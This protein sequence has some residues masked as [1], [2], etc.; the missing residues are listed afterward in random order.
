MGAS[1]SL[2]NLLQSEDPAIQNG[3]LNFGLSLLQSKG[4]FGNAI[5]RAGQAGQLGARDFRQ[6]QALLSR[7]S[8]NDELLKGNLEQQRRMLEMQNLPK[9]FMRPP[10][11]PGVDATGGMETAQ[12]NPANASGPG[13]F[14]MGG[15]VNALAGMDPLQALQLR[16][17]LQTQAP[18]PI[19]LGEGDQLLDP[20]TYKPVA[21]NPKAVKPADLP[22]A[23]QEY[24][25]A[26]SQGYKGTFNDWVKEKAKAGASS[27]SVSYGG[28]TAG[29]DPVTGQPVFFQA[30][31]KGGAPSIVQGVAPPKSD[32]PL[33]E[34][35]AKAATFKS[36]MEAAERELAGNPIDPTKLSSQI[37]VAVAS[38]GA[39]ILSSPAAQRA[40]QAQ[41]QWAESFLRFK[42]GAASTEAEVRRNV[43]TFFPQQ[44]D[45][46]AVID[47]KARMRQQAV[48]DLGFAATGKPA[49]VRPKAPI[50]PTQTATNPQTGEKLQLVNGEWVPVK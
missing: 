29:V 9:Q 43:K 1:M 19:K 41:E 49:E 4:N 21:S 12:E 13:G 27:T 46:K 25:F 39:N 23:V 20:T 31:N 37:D 2:F 11:T 5:G 47:Q 8:L 6:Q 38:T 22:N 42:T 7:T 45:S 34:A 18:Q 15:Y 33:T 14:D 50:A 44:G 32:K 24:Q 30:S 10:S 3:L 40:R 17:S 36:Q 26:S 35:Q 28:V 16:R 48:E